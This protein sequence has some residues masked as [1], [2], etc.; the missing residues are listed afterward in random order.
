MVVCALVLLAPFCLLAG[1][2]F[3]LL[4]RDPEGEGVPATL[5]YAL[6]SGG[7]LLGGCVT[8]FLLIPGLSKFDGFLAI[9]VVTCGAA[10]VSVGSPVS[11]GIAGAVSILALV[12]ALLPLSAR[13]DEWSRSWWP[14]GEGLFRT[15]DTPL[16]TV[17]VTET[18]G[19]YT[20]RD[21]G[22]W[23]GDTEGKPGAEEFVH[24]A[25]LSHAEPKTVALLGGG[26][27]GELAE[28]LKHGTEAHLALANAEFLETVRDFLPEAD[29]RALTRA[30]IHEKGGRAFLTEAARDGKRFDVVL[31]PVGDPTT[32]FLN[33]YYTTEFFTEVSRALAPGGLLAIHLSA[34]PGYQSPARVRLFASVHRS[35]REVFPRVSV[36]ETDHSGFVLL[37]SAAAFRT[38][39][40]VLARRFSSRKLETT[41]VNPA[42]I[43]SVDSRTGPPGLLRAVD[44]A[45]APANR[46]LRPASYLL[47]FSLWRSRFGAG[48]FFEAFFLLIPILALLPIAWFAGKG[49][50]REGR[51]RRLVLASAAVGFSGM[52]LEVGLLLAFHSK[53][54]AVY[55]YL[56]ALAAAFMAGAAA[57]AW[58]A[59]GAA[60]PARRGRILASGFGAFGL[61]AFLLIPLTASILS[62]PVAL[63]L[64]AALQLAA[65]GLTGAL[66][67][68]CLALFR[69]GESSEG[70]GLLYGADLTGAAWGAI[71]AGA[72]G[73]PWLG[74]PWT[75]LVAGG[76]GTLGAVLLPWRE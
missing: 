23:V 9:V 33:R 70:A 67:P 48:F 10:V 35:L 21:M 6:E 65:G 26:A 56:G 27:F 57:G 25:L 45:D 62:L 22:E 58:L 3:P 53:V 72:I 34:S 68:Q 75:L 44:E 51:R 13:T 15:Q 28:T 38:N 52:A 40:G 18:R 69:D 71:L 46:D 60:R 36:H 30:V 4:L 20:F 64:F 14:P 32:G 49:K 76:V 39:G 74:I 12:V 29:R 43:A 24:L 50:A 16:S 1:A 37:A 42:W 63:A 5:G 31:V 11:R 7:F 8:A 61:L 47:A 41:F 73:V 54:G 17:T 19:L 66:F 2:L 55:T 59:R